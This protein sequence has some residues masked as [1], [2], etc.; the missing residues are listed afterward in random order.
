MIHQIQRLLLFSLLFLFYYNNAVNAQIIPVNHP[1]NQQKRYEIDAKR[2]G[3]DIN[4]N[5]ALPRSREFLRIDST[6][7]IGWMYEGMYKINH[8]ADFL[9]YKNAIIPF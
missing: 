3:T 5:D 9:G 8:A 1:R 4:S 2:T 6:Y 7:Y